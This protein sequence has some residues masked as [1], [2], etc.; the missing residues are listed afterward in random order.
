MNARRFLLILLATV[1]SLSFSGPAHAQILQAS[2]TS[3]TQPM[4][5]ITVPSIVAGRTYQ[6]RVDPATAT[7]DSILALMNPSASTNGAAVAGSDGD[8]CGLGGGIGPACFEWLAPSGVPTSVQLRLWAYRSVHQGTG[9]V[10]SR[11]RVGTGAWSAW[12][13]VAHQLEAPQA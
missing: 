5:I 6:F 10:Q 3:A 8:A 11:W 13:E 7:G 4:Q 2:A 12:V 1:G 9:T